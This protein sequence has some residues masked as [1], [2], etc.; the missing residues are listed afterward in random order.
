MTT[1]EQVKD[2]LRELDLKF[3]DASGPGEEVLALNFMSDPDEVSYR[4][5]RGE[6]RMVLFV[7]LLEGGE[8]LSVLSG[9]GW[10]LA[11][12]VDKAAVFEVLA[13][14]STNF[15]MIRFDHCEED[16]EI[17]PNVE[18]ALED[19][20][21]TSR[22]LS[23]MFGCILQFVRKYDHVVMR[24][25]RGEEE[26]FSDLEGEESGRFLLSELRRVLKGRG[27]DE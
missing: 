24:A 10:N 25:I 18:I 13:N 15:K 14:L 21:L 2:L 26:E 16:G 1:L 22:Q 11:G 9:C 27:I 8:F 12:C 3:D 5:S 20:C 7:R 4:N 19:S 6:P 23:R 17:R